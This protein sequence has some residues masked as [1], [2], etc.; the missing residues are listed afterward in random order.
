M[1]NANSFES[2]FL[3]IRVYNEHFDLRWCIIKVIRTIIVVANNKFTNLNFYKNFFVPIY[4]YL[5]R[6]LSAFSNISA[7]T[8]M[9][10]DTVGVGR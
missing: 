2:C 5:F 1:I 3:E 10:G 9:R 6:K 4:V 7:W 8:C